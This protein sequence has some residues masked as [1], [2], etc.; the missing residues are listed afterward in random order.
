MTHQN[1]NEPLIEF[2]HFH[3]S[4]VLI[5]LTKSRRQLTSS[6]ILLF[7]GRKYP[8]N[9]KLYYS[10]FFFLITKIVSLVWRLTEGDRTKEE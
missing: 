7:S 5:F 2:G 6:N 9:C 8:G 3:N 10:F 1:A 4:D